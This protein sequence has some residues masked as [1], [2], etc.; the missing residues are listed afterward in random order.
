VDL[1]FKYRDNR[2][3]IR[4]LAHSDAG[5]LRVQTASDAG[6]PT[7]IDVPATEGRLLFAQ[8]RVLYEP[9]PD[10]EAASHG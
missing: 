9:A 5:D 6:S 10:A 8:L 7:V 3:E 1:L 2:D 4:I